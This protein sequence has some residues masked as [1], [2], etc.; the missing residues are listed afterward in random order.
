MISSSEIH[1]VRLPCCRMAVSY[2]GQFAVLCDFLTHFAWLRLNAVIGGLGDLDCLGAMDGDVM[3][4]D[5]LESSRQMD[6]GDGMMI[7]VLSLDKLIELKRRAGR[8]K[9]LAAIPYLEAT[10]DEISKKA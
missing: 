7:R 4:E 8:P 6:I 5:L 1:A 2:S 9:D 3:Y 10:L